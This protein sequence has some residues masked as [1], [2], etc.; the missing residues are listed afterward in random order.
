MNSNICSKVAVWGASGHSLVVDDIF[1]LMGNHKV[2]GFL[3][4]VNTDRYGTKFCQAYILGGQEQLDFLKL[5]EVHHLIV[6]IGNCRA[7][8]E[9][10]KLV[11][12]K[13]FRLATA[14]HPQSIVAQDVIIGE[15]TVIVGGSVINSGSKIGKN[16]IIN[17]CASVDHECAIGNGVHIGPGVRLGGLVQVKQGAWIGIG[18]V[19]SDR[20][21]IGSSSI[22]G[23]GAVVLKDVPDGVVVYGVPAKVIRKVEG[24]EC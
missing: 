3:D 15:G 23:A 5:N 7:R 16:V 14:I 11:E 22:V 24:Y 20:V 19:V 9:L 6:A 10:A 17:T 1:R 13:G 8:Q 18:A 4:D 21:T 12:E 2:F